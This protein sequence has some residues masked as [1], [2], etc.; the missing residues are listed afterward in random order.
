MGKKS[1]PPAPPDP[2]Q[3]AAAQT[4]TNVSTAVANAFLNNTSQVTPDYALQYDV[5]GSHSWTDPSTGK[6][7]QIPRFTAY[8]QLSPQQ[9]KLKDANYGADLNMANLARSQ[10]SRLNS[11][12]GRPI[13]V[14]DLPERPGIPGHYGYSNVQGFDGLDAGYARGGKITRSY[15]ADDFSK[16]RQKVENALM[17]RM[18][19]HLSRDREA[20]RTQ[21]S[22][23][24][25]KLGSEAYDRGMS[26]FSRQ[27]NDARLGAILNAGEEQA[28]MVGMDRDR[29]TFQNAAQSQA[30]GQHRSNIDAS[31]AALQQM[32][33]NYLGATQANNQLQDRRFNQD[34]TRYG[35]GMD[36]RKSAMQEEFALRNQPINEITALMSGSQVSPPNFMN[37]PQ[38]NIPTT[39]YAGIVGQNY[40]Q[41]LARYQM[42]QQNRPNILGGLF[43]L[44]AGYLAGGYPIP[45]IGGPT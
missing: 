36:A 33:Q 30:F 13:D 41:Q 1:K 14:G 18:N 28:R 8:Q 27:S 9:Q 2:R 26:D 11:L 39:D 12:L 23:Q 32:Y 42:Q 6:T 4:G 40:N 31:N 3:T 19:P 35:M 17:Q 5:T 10:S 25:I 21:M 45:G 38:Y 43:G 20:L 7:Y 24:G 22:N 34:A 16:D 15:G 37:T 44:G 29:A